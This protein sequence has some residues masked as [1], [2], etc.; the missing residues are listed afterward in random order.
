MKLL[1][2]IDLSPASAKVIEVAR[3]IAQATAAHVYV[4]HVAEPEPDFMGFEAG[5]DVVRDQVAEEFRQAHRA[6]QAFAESLREDGVETSALLVRGLNA[7]AE[8]AARSGVLRR[9]PP[10]QR[11][12]LVSP[13]D[14]WDHRRAVHRF[15]QDIPLGPADPAW[16]LVEESG[17][18]LGEFADR[19]VFIGWGLR[20][21]V[22]NRHFLDRFRQ[23]LPRADV[24]AYPD[25]GHYVLE[26]AHE[27]LRPA[28][29][30]FLDRNPV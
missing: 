18:Q 25:A 2:A 27:R 11:R 14:S 1:V 4:L 30:D 19:P 26:D 23:A 7:F 29:R 12:A 16:S 28:I 3:Q 22:F 21:F 10:D 15:V 9:L 5:P 17:R 20:D 8:G 13:Y 24:H 6:V